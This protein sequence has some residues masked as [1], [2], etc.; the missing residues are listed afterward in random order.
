MYSVVEALLNL[1]IN[2]FIISML[3]WMIFWDLEQSNPI[4][5]YWIPKVQKLFF[6]WGL[7]AQWQMFAPDPPRRTIWPMAKITL[8]NMETI[9]WEPKP[10]DK[11]NG[12]EKMR[13]KKFHNY[14]HD[15]V[16]PQS[17]DQLKQ[18]FAK[19]LLHK[20]KL[21][22][23]CVKVEVYLV[24]QPTQPFHAQ[25]LEKPTIDKQLVYTFDPTETE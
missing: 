25:S 2:V 19:Y 8:K 16:R 12:F 11:M 22:E 17:G 23:T 9:Y 3:F 24:A 10:Y 14:F 1:M 15:M 18:D 20:K 5:K 7:H 4:K 13:L 6:W 21:Q